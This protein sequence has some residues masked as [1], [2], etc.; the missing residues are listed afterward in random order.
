MNAKKAKKL[1]GLARAQTVGFVGS[2][3]LAKP[4]PDHQSVSAINNP[5]TYRGMYRNLKRASGRGLK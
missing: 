1:R 3:L 2:G 4:N 5:K